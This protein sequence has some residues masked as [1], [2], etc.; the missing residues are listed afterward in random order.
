MDQALIWIKHLSWFVLSWFSKNGNCAIVA[1]IASTEKT[2][3]NKLYWDYLIRQDELKKRE[4]SAERDCIKMEWD[5]NGRKTE[6]I[7]LI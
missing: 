4:R 5:E 2:K 7:I 6:C 1:A 3:I